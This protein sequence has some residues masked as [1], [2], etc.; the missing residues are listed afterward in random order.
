MKFPTARKEFTLFIDRGWDV[1]EWF[2]YLI[3]NAKVATVADTV[4]SEGRRMK[5]CW[6]KYMK[7]F[8]PSNDRTV[9]VLPHHDPLLSLCD[10]GDNIGILFSLNMSDCIKAMQGKYMKDKSE[11]NAVPVGY[12]TG[13]SIRTGIF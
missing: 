5:Q 8:P 9:C 6:I 3:A 4:E 2:E 7:K 12:I 10:F 11:I 13:Y 1:A